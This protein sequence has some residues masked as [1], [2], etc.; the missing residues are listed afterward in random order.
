MNIPRLISFRYLRHILNEP[1]TVYID[2][3]KIWQVSVMILVLVNKPVMELVMQM[4][5]VVK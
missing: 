1:H 4:L 3:N 5:E 2:G